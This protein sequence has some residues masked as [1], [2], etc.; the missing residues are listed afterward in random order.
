MTKLLVHN[1]IVS[2]LSRDELAAIIALCPF[3]AIERDGEK[4]EVN[5]GC[6]M[7]MKCVREG[8]AGV[9]GVLET[10]GRTAA[11]KSAWQGIAVFVELTEG[12]IHP[13]SLELVGK[14][15]ELARKAGFRVCAL[16]MGHN[17][18]GAAEELLHYG[19]DE[20]YL[21]DYRELDTFLIE[22]GANVFED[23]INRAKPSSILVGATVKGRSLA[24]RIAARMRTGL[25][26]DCTR[27]EIKEN[28]DL[29]QIRP[30][31]GGNI[32]AEITTPGNR[33]QIATVRYKIFDA[34]PR[35]TEARGKVT[36]CEVPEY[37]LASRTRPV[38]IAKKEKTKTISEADVIVAVG[39]GIKSEKDLEM[40]AALAELLGAEIA[41]TRPL[42]EAGWVSANRQ[43]GLSGRTVKPKLIIT[44]GISG[45]VQFKAGMENSGLIIS[46]NTDRNAEIFNASHMAVIGDIYDVV[47]RLMMRIKEGAACINR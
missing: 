42:V 30:A 40:A 26:A 3:A 31:F 19:V 34:P 11:D 44:L 14:A 17:A 29:I 15:N 13:V 27:L 6:R 5:A 41:A 36:Y 23:F 22:P 21:Y 37:R 43:I 8:P 9:F 47:P 39:R 4:L 20:V 10:G 32:M 28:T 2:T 1:E 16:L 7:C 18:K 12:M 46:V 25:T 24:P 35:R 38:S 45:S 33:P